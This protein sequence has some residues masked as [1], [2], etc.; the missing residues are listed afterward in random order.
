MPESV[1]REP[2]LAD[3]AAPGLGPRGRQSRA[4]AAAEAGSGPA[5]AEE[6]GARVL[7]DLAAGPSHISAVRAGLKPGD[8]SRAVHGELYEVMC[9]LADAGQ[10][11]HPVIMS[12]AAS[13]RGIEADAADLAS[14]LAVF[15]V[16]RRPGDIPA[17]ASRPDRQV[18]RDIQAPNG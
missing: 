11:V 14:G 6:A 18:G 3:V 1:R 13:Q 16:A 4:G 9:D 5:D 12:W 2:R 15:A 8:F 7:R 17:R 10:P